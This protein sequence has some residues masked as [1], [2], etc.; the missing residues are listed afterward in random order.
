MRRVI[1][2]NNKSTEIVY[3]CN[4]INNKNVRANELNLLEKHEDE[5]YF[6]F[7]ENNVNAKKRYYR[8]LKTLNQDF[9]ALE[10]IKRN[11]EN[12]KQKVNEDNDDLIMSNKNSSKFSRM[13]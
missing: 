3:R 4:S 5:L 13:N 8:D 9:Q 7:G 2:M 11:L 12:S 6:I 1:M 10:K